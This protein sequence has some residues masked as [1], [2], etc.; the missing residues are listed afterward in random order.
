MEFGNCFWLFCVQF[1]SIV[2][3]EFESKNRKNKKKKKKENQDF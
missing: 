3:F 1:S 2:G